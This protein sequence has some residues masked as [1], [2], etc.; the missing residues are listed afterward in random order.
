MSSPS[1]ERRLY[2]LDCD[3]S[4]WSSRQGRIVSCRTDGTDQQILVKDLH[5]LPDGIAIDHARGH[6]YWTNMGTAGFT[7][8]D[9]SIQRCDLAT[10]G[11]ITTILPPGTT[12]TPKQLVLA[13]QSQKLYWCDR[14][15]MR[16]MRAN[17]DGTAV[18]TLVQTGATPAD[19][20]DKSRWC[21]GIAVDERNNLLYWTQKGPSKGGVGRIYRAPIDGTT[22]RGEDPAT[23]GDVECLF[24]GLPEPID[25]EL[26]VERQLLYWTDRGDPPTGNTLNRAYVGPLEAGKQRERQILAIRFHET[27]GLALD[28]ENQI[29]YVTDLSGGVYRVKLEGDE[30]KK[31]VLIPELG[32]VTGIALGGH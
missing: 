30:G 17:L 14:E 28:E 25:L 4:H 29:A 20:A 27:I 23:R 22:L 9:G 21:V 18:E 1:Q 3:L 6:I 15:G 24:D 2:I 16:V 31:E 19:R 10:G 8:N 7:T 12:F 5:E 11:N 32:D 13:P 26:D